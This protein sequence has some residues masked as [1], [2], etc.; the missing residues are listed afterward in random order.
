MWIRLRLDISWRNL[1]CGFLGSLN[2]AGRKAARKELEKFWSEGQNDVLACLSVRS[3]FDLLL[4]A[5]DLPKGSE[6]LFSAITIQDMPKI[7]EA[8]GLVPVPVDLCGSDYHI[9]LAALE[10]AVSSESKVLVI[11]HLFGARPCMQEVLEFARQHNLYVVEDCAQAW[12]KRNW[13]GNDQADV[14]LFSFGVIK[15]A[16]ALG[17]A[18][19]RIN[20]PEILAR[21]RSLQ[22]LQPV[23]PCLDLTIK[24]GKYAFLK[25]ISTKFAF[26]G[27]TM[28]CRQ[29]GKNPDDVLGGLTR[30]FAGNNLFSKL[31]KQPNTGTLRLLKHR[32][33]TY[34][35]RRINQRINNAHFI[36][37][38]LGLDKTE[39]ELLNS[40]HSFWLFPLITDQA[41]ELIAHLRLHG[42]DTTQRG[43]LRVLPP[44]SKQRELTC[45]M[46]T[47]L[48][49]RTVMLPC[50]PE[51]PLKAIES[52]CELILDFSTEVA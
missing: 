16:T 38:K 10:Q 41:D 42:F 33:E 44:H 28:L 13:R 9:D 12:F 49:D 4:Q 48:L 22:A 50:Y 34:D 23:Q 51:M 3:G 35:S 52:M 21:M 29:F 36:I 11:A 39:P 46:A 6:V 17:G 25:A 27:I 37:E 26:G 45:P 30:S 20:N 31:R 5:M 40:Q 47:E 1:C 43:R 18:L 14:S 8:H 32:L 24:C 7:A 19:C 15:T 2:R